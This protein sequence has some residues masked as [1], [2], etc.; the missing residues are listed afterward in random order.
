MINFNYYSNF[1]MGGRLQIYLYQLAARTAPKQLFGSL[2][3]AMPPV[4]VCYLFI[5][6]IIFNLTGI[7]ESLLAYMSNSKTISP[8][9][10][11]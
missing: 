5:F 9:V 8:L 7:N 3:P 10:I 1:T 11:F 4:P 6:F 2:A